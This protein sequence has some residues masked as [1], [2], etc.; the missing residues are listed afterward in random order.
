MR[1][2]LGNT[3]DENLTRGC[4]VQSKYAIHCAMHEI[5]VR[6]LTIKII[7]SFICFLIE[8]LNKK[9][10]EIIRNGI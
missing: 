6:N 3:E 8:S 9:A 4:C 1:K 5:L 10:T 7:P 2:F